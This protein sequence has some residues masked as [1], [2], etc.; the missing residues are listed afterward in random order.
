ML[1]PT[2]RRTCAPRGQTPILKSYGR[3]D[4]LNAVSA[5]TVSPRRRLLGIVFDLLDHNLATEDFEVCVDRLLRKI[6]GPITLVID[7]LGANKSASQRLLVEYPARLAFEWLPPYWPDLNPTEHILGQYDVQ[8]L[9][10]LH[11]R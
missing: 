1:Q 6:C 5:V 2:V 3:H 8:L 7:R 10:Q 11:S 4:R 9:G